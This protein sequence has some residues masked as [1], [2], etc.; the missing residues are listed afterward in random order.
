M[1]LGAAVRRVLVV[2]K[3]IFAI[4]RLGLA[5]PPVALAFE[6]GLGDIGLGDERRVV[7]LVGMAA[8]VGL[9]QVGHAQR[10]GLSVLVRLV[11]KTPLDHLG[12]VDTGLAQALHGQADA[13]QTGRLGRVRAADAGA[14][15][16]DDHGG[17]LARP[18]LGQ[19]LDGAGRNAGDRRRPLGRLRNA[20]LFTHDVGLV[21]LHAD[22]V[23]LE[24]LL[25][26][27]AVLEPLI[28]DGQVE[29]RVGV[30]Q[31]RDPPVGV[32][33][34]GVVEVR[35]HVDLL[36]AQLGPPVAETARQLALPAPRR[37]FLI[38]APEKEQLGVL[39]DVVE[40]VALHPLADRLAAPEVLASPPPAFPAVGLTVLLREAAPQAEQLA[41]G[42]M[43]GLH[44][45]VLSVLVALVENS[46]G[47]VL[48][49]DAIH[50]ADDDVK[51]LVPGDA[52]KLA[53][54]AVLRVAVA[55]GVEVDTHH[56]V[57]DPRRRIDA[58]LVGDGVRRNQGFHAGLEGLAPHFHLPGV[59]ILLRIVLPIVVHRADTD[60]L[61]ILDVHHRRVGTVLRYT[62]EA[63]IP[64]QRLLCPLPL[65]RFLLFFCHE[66]PPL[67]L[68]FRNVTTDA[69]LGLPGSLSAWL[70]TLYH[71][72][73]M[74]CKHESTGARLCTDRI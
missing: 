39:G 29:R 42:A 17:A 61:A 66:S 54:A 7:C 19:R 32:H 12:L 65:P 15:V 48:L 28:G 11:E 37:G 74:S 34:G 49:L 43:A 44:D 70:S 40:Q 50:L 31:H 9:A 36:D 22:G 64:Y 33:C 14:A 51:R 30:G 26:V 25:V 56:G 72:H 5:A 4:G 21:L 41:A 62:A 67:L 53:D 68:N 63:D 57:A 10:L 23:R 35:G 13:L 8:G 2:H 47:T 46:R 18:F 3:L 6:D 27:G 71:I 69:A 55:V 38:A 16:A 1:D 24:V 58:L 52:L 45:L 59:H 73:F 60:D 20:V